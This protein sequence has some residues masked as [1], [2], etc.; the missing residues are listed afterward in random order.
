MAHYVWVTK[1][2]L[3]AFR[4]GWAAAEKG[5]SRRERP[6][7]PTYNE[8]AAFKDGWDTR[9]AQLKAAHKGEVWGDG[10]KG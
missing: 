8:R 4:E 10:F 2:E 9:S 3:K 1:A 7:Y 6:L 5:L